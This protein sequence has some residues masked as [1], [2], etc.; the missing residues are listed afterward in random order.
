MINQGEHELTVG[1]S[2]MNLR[3]LLVVRAGFV[4]LVE[5]S[6]QL[7]DYLFFKGVV[8]ACSF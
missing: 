4:E 1:I 5:D 3:Q 2:Y 7:I 6:R 8:L